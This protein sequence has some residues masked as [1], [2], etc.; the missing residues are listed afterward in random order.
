VE[1]LVVIFDVRTHRVAQP[2]RLASE[3]Q[4]RLPERV[5]LPIPELHRLPAPTLAELG[6][7]KNLADRARKMAAV[8]KK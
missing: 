7:D 2:I 3:Q 4:N 1:S 8:P 5:D 6:I